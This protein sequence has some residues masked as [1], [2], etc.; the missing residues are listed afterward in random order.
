MSEFDDPI[1]RDRLSR[2]AG[3]A[4]GD[5]AAYAGVQSRVRQVK[6]RRVA[7]WSGAA[8][9]V[10]GV[11]A[12]G[13]LTGPDG[14]KVTVRPADETELSTSSSASS[15]SSSSTSTSIEGTT[16]IASTVPT[17]EVTTGST[18]DDGDSSGPGSG[19]GPGGTG[20]SGG[21]NATSPTQPT[22]PTQPVAPAPQD[23]SRSAIGG[24]LSVRLTDGS[25]TILAVTPTTGFGADIKDSSGDRIRVEFESADHRSRVTAEIAN[26]GIVFTVEEDARGGDVTSPTAETGGG[27]GDGPTTT[28]DRDDSGGDSSGSGSGSGSSDDD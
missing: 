25:L 17:S 8:A 13:A 26:G 15:A 23:G 27:G 1:L 4:P 9:I 10:I 16:T 28:D 5:D 22:Q 24:T 14:T 20:P 6:R 19:S 2:Y 21:T 3:T 12:A 18:V 11:G 7:V